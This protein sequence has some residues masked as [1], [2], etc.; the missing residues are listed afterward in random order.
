[1]NIALC[2][3][4]VLPSRG[5]CETYICDLARRL[6]HDGHSVH[7][8]S[9]H[10]DASALPASTHFY[11]L[12]Q[13]SGPRFV[14]PWKFSADCQAALRV[15][16]PDVSIG[17]DKTWG[18]DILYPQGG[19]HAATVAHNILK[20]PNPV[21]RRLARVGKWFEPAN[22]AYTQIE[23]KQ[24]FGSHR[25]IIL[26]NSE[27][28]RSH[29]EQ[30]YGVIPGTVR[31]LRSAIDPMRFLAEDRPKRR[32]EERDRWGVTPETNVGLF[33]A[34][35]YRLKGLAPLLKSLPGVPRESNFRLVVIGDSHF[36]QYEQLAKSLGV[37]DRVSFLG[38]RNDPKD[39]YFGADFLVHPTFYDPCSLVVLES[40]ACGLPVVT[41]RYNGA[42]ELLNASN[43]V[44]VN[45]PHDEN[46]LARAIT[47]FTAAS[48]R[49]AATTAAREAANS[50]TFNHHYR[51]LL[52]IFEEATV[53]KQAA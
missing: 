39:A 53:L 14:R 12:L 32:A 50:W 27:M 42:S 43:S 33:I 20:H 37:A 25:P 30:Y 41:S 15:V 38:F 49:A 23:R 16:K 24:Y 17:F 11:R 21:M 1:M 5:G 28:V 8:F 9:C 7:L 52:N 47:R 4:S 36:S 6:A 26:V 22:W 31:V 34:T 29:F 46:E 51:S 45:D 35:N 2:H 18:Q 19:L 10:W 40:L 44:V 3:P 13:P 48:V